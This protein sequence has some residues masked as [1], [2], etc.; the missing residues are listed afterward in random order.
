VLDDALLSSSDITEAFHQAA[1]WLDICALNG[2]TL[3]PAKFCFAKD[4]VDFAGFTVTPNE[5]RPADKFMVVIRDYPNPTSLT[6]VRAWFG[7][8][9]Q[10]SYTFAMTSAMLPFRELLKQST[11]FK[12]TDKLS[13]ALTASKNHICSSILTGVEIFDKG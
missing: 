3:N 7:L 13:D 9:N 8:V 11:P 10:V 12:W 6:N 2:I 1:E 5:V 4:R